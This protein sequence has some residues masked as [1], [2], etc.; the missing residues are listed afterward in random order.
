MT[1]K[2]YLTLLTTLLLLLGLALPAG[3][4]QTNAVL[5]PAAYLPVI[6]NSPPPVNLVADHTHASLAQ[7]PPE[8]VTAAREKVVWIYGHTSHGSQLISGAQYLSTY[9]SPPIYK[10]LSAYLVPPAQTSPTGLRVGDDGGWSWSEDAFLQSARNHLNAVSIP[11]G[12]QG[13]FMWSWCGEMSWLSTTSVQHYLDMLVQ[14][15]AEYPAVRF[16]RMTG[17]TDGTSGPTSVLLRNNQMVRATRWPTTAPCSTSPISNPGCQMARCTP[18]SRMTAARGARPGAIRTP[19]PAPTRPSRAPIRTRSTAISKARPSGG[20]RRAWRAGMGI[21]D[22][23]QL[24]P[25]LTWPG[26]L[27]RLGP[28]GWASFLPRAEQDDHPGRLP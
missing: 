23:I 2:R 14:L 15:E 17:H 24:C 3:A 25:L 10:L 6:F 22:K 1:V 5:L 20:S 26:R 11:A 7:I 4:A 13:V 8:W 12:S 16:V 28:Q 21:P 27:H 19:A 9:V 18:A